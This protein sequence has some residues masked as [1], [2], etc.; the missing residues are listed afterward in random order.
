MI[1]PNNTTVRPRHQARIV[2]LQVLYQLD[3]RRE[4]IDINV[5]EIVSRLA[6]ESEL[7]GEAAD[8]SHR[9]AAGSWAN[10]QRY[11]AMI[12]EV[13]AHWELARMAFVDRNILRLALQEITEHPDVPG[14]VV[15][16]EAIEL[17][18]EFGDEHTP[19]FINGVLDA[20]W[21]QRTAHPAG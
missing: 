21:K 4:P 7:T 1:Q 10:H 11:D 20:I 19:Q 8:Y 15:I 13:S 9:L 17:G 2:A 12:V 3:M 14:R 18:R 6:A 5:S 16:D